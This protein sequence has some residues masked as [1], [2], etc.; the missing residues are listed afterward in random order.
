MLDE[1]EIVKRV[2]ALYLVSTPIGN[3]EDITLRALRILKECDLIAAEDTRVTRKLLSHFDIHTPLTSYHQH[4]R[5]NRSEA[6]IQKLKDGASVALVTDAGAPGVSDPGADLV[7]RAIAVGVLVVPIPGASAV[8]AGLTASGLPTGRFA[9]DGFP[10]RTKTDRTA[11]FSALVSE[12]RTIVLYEAPSRLLATLREL[13]RHL[14]DREVAV[15]R[16]LTKKFEEVF[17]GRLSGAVEHFQAKSPRGEFT[18]VVHGAPP[19]PE[20]ALPDVDVVEKGL[21]RALS[22][23]LSGR[24]AVRRVTEELKLPRR[25]VYSVLLE[26]SSKPGD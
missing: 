11:F 23:G 5:E 19:P 18:L 16:E 6:L 10:P 1:G 15:A 8:L 12:R 26:I 7:S 21:R 13:E 22:D 20:P 24:D 4:T 14:G 3:L 17:R 25:H 9:F 2:G